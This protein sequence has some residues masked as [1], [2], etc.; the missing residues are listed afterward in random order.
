MGKIVKHYNEFGGI[1]TRTNKLVMAPSNFRSGSYNWRYAIDDTIG[2]RPGIQAKFGGSVNLACGLMEYKYRDINTEQIL[3]QKLSVSTSGKLYRLDYHSLVLARSTSST[4]YFYSFFYDDS[5]SLY[6]FSVYDINQAVLNTTTVSGSMTLNTLKTTINGWAITGFTASTL[7]SSGNTVTSSELAIYLDVQY[8]FSFKVKDSVTNELWFATL[9]KAPGDVAIFE[10]ISNQGY[11]NPNWEGISYTN[12]NNCIYMTDGGFPVKYDGYSV[13]RAGMP[14]V[15]RDNALSDILPDPS[16][17][18]GYSNFAVTGGHSASSELEDGTYIYKF[19]YGFIDANGNEIL[20]RVS[21]PHAFTATTSTNKAY[22]KWKISAIKNTNTFPV[23]GCKVNGNQDPSATTFTLTVDTG[24]NIQAGMYLRVPIQ[25]YVATMIDLPFY[26]Y[27]WAYLLVNSVTST[28]LN[29]TGNYND[30]YCIQAENDGSTHTF[31]DDT[32]LNA[33]FGPSFLTNKI[34]D[35]VNVPGLVSDIRVGAFVRVFKTVKNATSAGPFYHL[36]DVAVPADGTVYEF[37]DKYADAV[38]GAHN[39]GYLSR[40]SLD[41]EGESLPRACR[42]IG[43]WQNQLVQGGRPY[44]STLAA[45][46]YPTNFQGLNYGVNNFGFPTTNQSILRSYTEVHLAGYQ[47][48][49][50][51]DDINIEGFPQDGSSEE[52]F[53]NVFNDEIMGFRELRNDLFV[54]KNRSCGVLVGPLATGGYQKEIFEEDAGLA[55]NSSIDEVEGTLVW[56]DPD[57]GFWSVT[58]GQKPRLMSYQIENLFTQ[59]DTLPVGSKFNFR[60]AK[61]ANYRIDDKYYCFVPVETYTMLTGVTD[62]YP[63]PNSSS[64]LFV[65][66]YGDASN[67]KKRNCWLIDKGFNAGGGMLASAD[68]KLIFMQ[69][70]TSASALVGSPVYQK[71]TGTRFDFTDSQDII[72]MYIKTGW[73]SLGAPSIDK[74]WIS[75]VINSI[76]GGFNLRIDQFFAFMDYV[77]AQYSKDLLVDSSTKISPKMAIS[78]NKVKAPAISIGLYNNEKNTVV[79]INGYELEYEAEYD[80]G[81]VR[82]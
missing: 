42:Y 39:F 56:L 18:I 20:G 10:Y 73:Q 60:R 68:N 44:D 70:T 29:L 31:P 26:G 47:S 28:T 48:V 66:D 41:N 49:Y 74:N 23:Y 6:R 14:E 62:P 82:K 71:R 4:A 54:F 5:V 1:D 22:A 46:I 59:N 65:F 3:T 43:K 80:L 21:D 57:K 77:K 52:S 2:K 7:D 27:S 79:S 64:L 78:A 69:S 34:E 67:G 33:G 35:W 40:I 58:N 37:I 25:N 45:V 13:Y 61:A 36:T 55:T 9:I 24:H 16:V 76:A 30:V 38:G 51:A 72:E 12:L 63:I 50:F 17:F 53:D 75:I 81:E 8:L 32:Y 19:Q 15:I 11:T